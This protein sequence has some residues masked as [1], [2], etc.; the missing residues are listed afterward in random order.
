M[1]TEQDRIKH[2]KAY[3]KEHY[4][5]N[6]EKK[7]EYQKVYNLNNKER[8]KE[9]K[10]EYELKH[11][12]KRRQSNKEYHLKNK[13]KRREYRKEYNLK[14]KE[15][16]KEYNREYNREYSLKIKEHKKEYY[17]K[18]KEQIKEYNLNN[19]ERFN[20]WRRSYA[21]KRYKTDINYK[22][23]MLCSNRV[24]VALKGKIKSARTMELIG[25]TPNELRRHIESLFEPWMTWENQGRGGWDI[26]HI[27]ACFHFN[28]ANSE[29]QRA[30]FNW[31]NLQ[32]MEHIANL[33]KGN[34]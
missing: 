22:L 29:Q 34:R 1:R 26:D 5:K 15:Y 23:R 31:S 16:K 28:L 20:E 9:R 11:K 25:C 12:E 30:C 10:K 17:L 32:P 33:Q 6:K 14:N 4:L 13:E 18:N 19:K 2:K 8:I 27:K 21:R 3:M 24:L 7:L